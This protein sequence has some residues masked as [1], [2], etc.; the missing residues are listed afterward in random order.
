MAHER[1]DEH[2]RRHGYRTFAEMAEL[3]ETN[4][5]FDLGSTLIAK[6]AEIGSGNVF[7][8]GVIVHCDG[9]GCVIG[10]NNTFFPSTLLLAEAGGRIAIGDACTFG[11][12]GVQIKANRPGAE[13]HV[14][15]RVRVLNGAE[16]VGSSVL[17]SGSQIIGA[18]AAQSVR[19]GAGDDFEGPDPDTRGAVL[20]GFG[21][22]RGIWLE[23]GDVVNGS[24]D[25]AA[26]PVERQLS[27]HPRVAR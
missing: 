8:P 2:R 16:I 27:Y 5:I 18:V 6:N 4:T 13:L 22:A 7:Y 21:L 10:Q 3:A 9:G 1:L 24:G 25:F 20:K 26:A 19:L 15:D 23:A 14:G 12:G 11:P 17:G